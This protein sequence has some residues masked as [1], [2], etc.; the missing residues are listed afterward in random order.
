MRENLIINNFKFMNKIPERP[1]RN[2]NNISKQTDEM[3]V[4]KIHQN[5]M[6]YGANAKEWMR[7]CVLLLPEIEKHR[8]WEKKGFSCI[9]EYAAKLAGMSR[10]TVD[11][12]L[13][14][15]K[16][17]EDKPALKQVVEEKGLNAVRPVITIAT[18]ETEGFWAEKAM[19][20]S[21]NTLEIYVKEIRPRTAKNARNSH[22]QA[23]ED[24]ALDNLQQGKA[25]AQKKTVIMELDTDIAE[26]L[27]KLKG[28]GDWNV[29]MKE[30]LQARKAQMEAQK[31]M[32][33]ETESR[34][35]PAKIKKYVTARTNN[36]CSFPR[37]TRQA[38]ILHHTQR[39]ALEHIHD[40]DRLEPLCK[41]HERLVHLGL[42]DKEEL[43]ANEWRL[44]KE[45]D[46]SE[47]KYKVDVLVARY[48]TP[49]TSTALHFSRI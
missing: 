41:A 18:P 20:M 19:A 28:S 22:Q 21:K 6:L 5:F 48:R 2:T 25:S 29:L 7:K 30:L 32:P 38:K 44:R 43:P 13:R 34:H 9:Y 37:C 1:L 10:N 11:D 15:L 46:K 40:P 31:P 35:I 42:V 12:A 47:P 17:I 33:V 16:K 39:Y 36:T 27:Q 26:Q 45:P 4:Q 14:I 23:I 49:T 24:Q 3:N 8:I